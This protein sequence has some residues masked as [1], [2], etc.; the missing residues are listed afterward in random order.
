MVRGPLSQR[1]NTAVS[2]TTVRIY[3]NDDLPNW[4]ADE[5]RFLTKPDGENRALFSDFAHD[6]DRSKLP[7]DSKFAI[8]YNDKDYEL[9]PIGW[10]MASLWEGVTCIQGFVKED[11]RQR[12]I[13]AALSALALADHPKETIGVFSDHFA[14]IG[15]WLGY[16][17]VR[18]YTRVEDGWII[19]DGAEP[20]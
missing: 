3:S 13:A 16:K 5:I 6:N 1:M 18:Q 8:A 9:Q 4:V 15:R 12:K 11:M 10:V 17:I 2:M 19:K 20:E 7:P 14:R